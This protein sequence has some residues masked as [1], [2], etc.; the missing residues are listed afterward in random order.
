[1]KRLQTVL[2][3]SVLCLSLFG[4][5]ACGGA[6][7]TQSAEPAAAPEAAPEA[8]ETAATEAPTADEAP[9]GEGSYEAAYPE[10]VDAEGLS[11]QDVEQQEE[12]ESHGH[13]EGEGEGEH[14]HGEDGHGGGEDGNGP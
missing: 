9:A 6:E 7:D 13:G 8:S 11:E 12:A 5:V 10:E 1:M 2:L 4:L 3:A 14:S